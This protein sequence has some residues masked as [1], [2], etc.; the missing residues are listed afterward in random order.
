ML[1]SL[2]LDIPRGHVSQR[3]SIKLLFTF[4]ISQPATHPVYFTILDTIN[5]QT[6]WLLVRKRAIPIA[7]PPGLAGRG[8]RVVSAKDPYGR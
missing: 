8:C 2:R 5:K 3:F 7:R 1:F 4:L 6:P